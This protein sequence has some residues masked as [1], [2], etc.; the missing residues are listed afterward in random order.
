[1]ASVIFTGIDALRMV[2]ETETDANSPDNE[3]TYGAIRKAI[4]T[5][6]LLLLGTA[7]LVRLRVIHPIT[8]PEF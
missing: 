6:F 4:E 7:I 5:L 3:T 2:L 8:R 1:M